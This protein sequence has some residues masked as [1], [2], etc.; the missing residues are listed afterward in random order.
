MKCN[1]LYIENLKNLDVALKQCQEAGTACTGVSI[2]GCN[3]PYHPNYSI[4]LCA[5]ELRT[6]SIYGSCS[7]AK[8]SLKLKLDNH[9]VIVYTLNILRKIRQFY[10]FIF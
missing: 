7:Y 4:D 6:D 9:F 5:G 1:K 2:H 3:D 10:I 8:G